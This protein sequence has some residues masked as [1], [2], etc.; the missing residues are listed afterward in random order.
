MQSREATKMLTLS[1]H[2][3]GHSDLRYMKWLFQQL[4]GPVYVAGWEDRE[5]C[6][7]VDIPRCLDALRAAWSLKMSAAFYWK[8]PILAAGDCIGYIT[9]TE[10]ALCMCVCQQP[11]SDGKRIALVPMLTATSTGLSNHHLCSHGACKAIGGQHS[12]LWR[13]RGMRGCP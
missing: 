7:V 6:T 3:H 10:P 9:G 5:D 1:I 12:A 8:Q 11:L 2:G 13:R 4:E